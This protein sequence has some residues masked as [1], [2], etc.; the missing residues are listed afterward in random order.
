MDNKVCKY[1]IAGLLLLCASASFAVSNN[2][3]PVVVTVSGGSVWE[4]AGKAQ[5]LNLASEVV[6]TYTTTRSSHAV[7][8]GDIFVAIQQNLCPMLLGQWGLDFGATGDARILGDIWDDADPEFNNFTY[9]YQVSHTHILAR[10]KLL[11]NFGWSVLPWISAG[12]GVGYNRA[13]SFSNKPTIEETL[14][15]PD[16]SANTISSFT[17]TLGAGVQQILDKNWQI[18]IGY[19]FADWGKSQLGT[20]QGQTLGKGLKLNHLYTNGVLLNITYCS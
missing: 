11:G 17:Y 2:Y 19:E 9:R 14:P 5:T 18:G 12:L 13:H 20:A 8:D 1:I 15:N 7:A 3:I 6:K 16:F 10:G 4:Q